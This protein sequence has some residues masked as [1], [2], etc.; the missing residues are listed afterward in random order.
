MVRTQYRNLVWSLV[1]PMA[2][3]LVISM[4]AFNQL[5]ASEPFR[6]WR[7]ATGNFQVEARFIGQKN[8]RIELEKRD[9]SR[10]TVDVKKLSLVDLRYI[11]QIVKKPKEE[12]KH[13]QSEEEA[14][15]AS[16]NPPIA[17]QE[18]S[19]SLP[20]EMA[21]EPSI[22]QEIKSIASSQ[23]L[24]AVDSEFVDQSSPLPGWELKPE[25]LRS[26]YQ[27]LRLNG[28]RQEIQSEFYK[29]LFRGASPN[30]RFAVIGYEKDYSLKKSTLVFVDFESSN[31]LKRL[32]LGEDISAFAFNASG[33][34]VAVYSSLGKPFISIYDV[35]TGNAIWTQ[36]INFSANQVELRFLPD[37]N[38]FFGYQDLSSSVFGRIL[39]GKDGSVKRL[40][41]TLQGNNPLLSTFARD[42]AISPSGTTLVRGIEVDKIFF[43]DL[44][45]N[46]EET[47]WTLKGASPLSSGSSCIL[48]FSE[49]GSELNILIPTPKGLEFVCL[50]MKSGD[51]LSIHNLGNNS[52]AT[53]R[54]YFNRTDFQIDKLPSGRGWLL[55]GTC[56]LDR[57]SGM[58]LWTAPIINRD[59]I[60]VNPIDEGKIFYL[61]SENRTSTIEYVDIPWERIDDKSNQSDPAM[62][63]AD[64]S[65]IST[66]IPSPI[67]PSKSVV[68]ES[69]PF[70]FDNTS[71][72]LMDPKG[73]TP[74]EIGVYR[75]ASVKPWNGDHINPIVTLKKEMEFSNMFSAIRNPARLFF[76][77]QDYK[78]EKRPF[79]GK[80]TI[81]RLD[82]LWMLDL[83]QLN[84]IPTRISSGVEG[85]MV[86]DISPKGTRAMF[87]AGE[88]SRRL[89]IVDIATKAVLHDFVPAK[90]THAAVAINS[91]FIDEDRIALGMCEGI[92]T[93]YDFVAKKPLY[94]F[95]CANNSIGLFPSSPLFVCH[96]N[97]N[98]TI[99]DCETGSVRGLVS[100]TDLS[101]MSLVSDFEI[102]SSEERLG[103]L[104]TSGNFRLFNLSTGKLDYIAHASNA[105]RFTLVGD[106]RVA[107]WIP[108]KPEQQSRHEGR[109]NATSIWLYN[110]DKKRTETQML[111]PPELT[112]FSMNQQ[113]TSGLITMC[114]RN[115]RTSELTIALRGVLSE[116]LRKK[117]DG[118]LPV[119]RLIPIDESIAIEI[120]FADFHSPS[121]EEEQ[122]QLQAKPILQQALVDSLNASRIQVGLRGTHKLRAILA[123]VDRNTKPRPLNGRP[124]QSHSSTE[125]KRR[126]EKEYQVVVSMTLT[127]LEG[128]VIWSSNDPEAITSGPNATAIHGFFSDNFVAVSSMKNYFDSWL[129]SY[130]TIESLTAPDSR[131]PA[132]VTIL[133][134]DEDGILFADN[135]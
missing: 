40:L 135:S 68:V 105:S 66:E 1:V 18:E 72:P 102:T 86:V 79:N 56:I 31:E 52:P 38:L 6:T 125:A 29:P 116:S 54:Y 134:I 99:R 126:N 80:S 62:N 27:P 45:N 58:I 120:E 75:H 129:K 89:V 34:R 96:S 61:R 10:L 73:K 2:T 23:E 97:P 50:S 28:R 107:F 78:L 22:P 130:L 106:Y 63:I 110:L 84:P 108:L 87:I 131:Y 4:A 74:S 121:K 53:L 15:K 91:E 95:T 8:G 41:K 69:S 59:S 122:I 103:V 26:P 101:E 128:A 109:I 3:C 90:H 77:S 76:T 51:V 33:D 39:D 13:K 65:K 70:N 112:P 111:L 85:A 35:Q 88:D 67:S 60:V 124:F 21:Q 93:V 5:Q 17:P 117:L 94:R 16:D 100:D 82:H 132:S 47:S 81:F 64:A 42:I 20:K 32:A 92:R 48:D 44:T 25:M 24:P 123:I 98:L 83:N 71:T 115:P 119:K 114:E 133:G 118:L 14:S 11:K 12:P 37:G 127:N 36:D 49:D 9:A 104:D 46:L 7:A 19:N 57:K 43:T 55:D 30:R 113:S